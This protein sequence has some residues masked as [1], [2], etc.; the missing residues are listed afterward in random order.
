[1]NESAMDPD[2][3]LAGFT[4]VER[5]GDRSWR[6]ARGPQSSLSFTA[7]GAARMRLSYA[8]MNPMKGQGYTLTAN[9]E[10]VGGEKGM[11][12]QN[13]TEEH[14]VKVV[15][16][17]A[18]PGRNTIAFRFEKINHVN[19]SF[20]ETDASPYTAAFTVLRLEPVTGSPEQTQ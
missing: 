7:G 20:S 1:M 10:P 15:E 14:P 3:E 5:E 13:W 11:L 17:T 2:F 16:F 9:E 4:S 18:K 6:W 8:L 12:T 19:D